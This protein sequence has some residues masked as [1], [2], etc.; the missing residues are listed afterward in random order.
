VGITTGNNVTLVDTGGIDLA[1]S[2]VS[3]TL[4]VTTTGAITDSGNV[5]VSGAT[6]L[7]AGAANDITLNSAG[8]NFSTVG[9]T[10]GN[11]VTL[12]DTGGID[13]AASTVSGT[14]SVTTT[15]A[16]TDSG[17]LAVTGAATF[18][19]GAANNI[20]L[21]QAG[22]NFST[23]GITTGNNVTLVD[24]GGIDLAASTVSGTLS[25]TTTGA[26]TDSGNLA[27]TGT[28]S[29][30]A[31][32]ASGPI[33][34]DS[35]GNDFTGVVTLSNSGANAVQITDANAIS[36]SALTLGGAF[37]VNA[38]GLITTAGVTNTGN[39]QYNGALS[40]NGTYTTNGG[41][42]AVTGATTLAG[43]TTVNAGAGTIT[44]TTVNGGFAL[45]ANSTTNE[46]FGSSAAPRR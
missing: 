43:G 10:T 13:L 16:I 39:Q 17:N 29:I 36:F 1:A 12:V 27:V 21:D 15:G 19:A 14:L 6:T 44:F 18:A 22:N 2:T 31:S 26:I 33:T 23:V 24:T 34:L 32:G 9:I 20:T 35:A 37:T 11:N 38:G 8:N 5:V 45:A 28:S 4:S 3:G 25:V 7:A 30:T 46:T 40:T 41:N 42:F